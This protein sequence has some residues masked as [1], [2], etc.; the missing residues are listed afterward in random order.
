VFGVHLQVIDPKG[1]ENNNI[2]YLWR[3]P[4]I[5]WLAGWAT[6]PGEPGHRWTSQ[7]YGLCPNEWLP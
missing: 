5:W 1:S 7:L 3:Q 4:D 6:P 2:I